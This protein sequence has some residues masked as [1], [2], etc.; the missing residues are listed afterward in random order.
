MSNETEAPA[1][2]RRL[3]V[4][5]P[6]LV[7]LG[8][9][10]LFLSQ[11]LSGRDTSEIP[12][13]LIGLPAPQ[14]SLPP[15]EGM[16]LP[17]L[18][19]KS[20]A[21]R[22]TLVN[23]FAS[24]C[25]PCREEHPVLLGLSQDKRFTLAALNYKDQPENARRFLGELGNPYQ[26]IGVDPAGRAAIDWGVYGVPETFVVGKD[27]KIAYKHVGPLTPDSV[28]ALLLPQIEKALS[29]PG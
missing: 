7:F 14:T 1:P 24:W 28:R 26:A 4:L 17:G 25:A 3:F 11:L 5:L 29:A 16:N 2:R 27:G 18:E 15:L 12:S 13:A 21:G 9:A 22:V 6:L 10:G 8:L 23:V 20:F 19:S